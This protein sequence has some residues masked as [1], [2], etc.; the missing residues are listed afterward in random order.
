MIAGFSII[1]ISI[2]TLVLASVGYSL[3]SEQLEVLITKLS[4][5][6]AIYAVIQK[7]DAY[8]QILENYTAL[9]EILIGYASPILVFIT[10][11]WIGWFFAI[12][13]NEVITRMKL[14][15]LFI[16]ISIVY[17]LARAIILLLLIIIICAQFEWFDK[18]DYAQA[19]SLQ[20]GGALLKR[21]SRTEGTPDFIK[22]Y[23][24]QYTYKNNYQPIPKPF[25]KEEDKQLPDFNQKLK[26]ATEKIKESQNILE[27][28]LEEDASPTFLHE[29][30]E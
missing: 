20:I 19:K 29:Q 26:E 14:N 5:L 16:P 24:K 11:Q 7:G 25:I 23:L 4:F 1:D 17:G 30:I 28:T 13:F 9:S 27:R 10:V 12:A 8:T 18:K 21:I 22:D 15:F 2:L 6:V 3:Q